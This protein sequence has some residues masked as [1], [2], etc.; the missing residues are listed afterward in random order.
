MRLSKK[1]FVISILGICAIT[2]SGVAMAASGSSTPTSLGTP[3]PTYIVSL[4]KTMA[5]QMGDAT[6]SAAQYV[7]TSRGAAESLLSGNTVDTNSTVIL[8]VLHGKFRDPYARMPKGAPA[9]TGTEINFTVNPITH[10][11]LDFGISNQPM[12]NLS[13]LGKLEPFTIP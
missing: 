4:A 10:V 6:P 13:I 9:P 7:Q 1:Y 5:A 11:I 3:P 2:G 8:V 12:N